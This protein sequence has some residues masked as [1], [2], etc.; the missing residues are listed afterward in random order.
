[1]DFRTEYLVDQQVALNFAIGGV[2]Q[3]EDVS[4]ANLVGGSGGHSSVVRVVVH[5]VDHHVVPGFCDMRHLE[6]VM[7]CLISAIRQTRHVL[8]L[9]PYV[10]AAKSFSES[11]HFLKRCWQVRNID[12]RQLVNVGLELFGGEDLICGHI[13][14]D[15]SSGH[16]G[17]DSSSSGGIKVI[18]SIA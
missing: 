9:D 17:S 1:M 13:V 6:L 5:D 4:Y 2:L 7:A 15:C 14:Q 3:N 16:E 12:S 10:G 8:T 18:L 11:W